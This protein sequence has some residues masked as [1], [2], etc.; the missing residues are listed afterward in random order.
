MRVLDE[1]GCKQNHK[2]RVRIS[3][4]HETA[5]TRRTSL[6]L[7]SRSLTHRPPN[8]NCLAGC[9]KSISTKSSS[10][11]PSLS[12]CFSFRRRLATRRDGFPAPEGRER[13]LPGENAS[14]IFTDLRNQ[15]LKPRRRAAASRTCLGNLRRASG[16]ARPP[17]NLPAVVFEAG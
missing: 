7:S 5:E 2:V 13:H 10:L 15:Y 6:S 4:S 16:V 17:S 9:E 3:V 14:L 8:T 12:L 1:N 11:L